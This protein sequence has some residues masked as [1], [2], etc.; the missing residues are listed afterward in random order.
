MLE[1]PKLFLDLKSFW[2]VL[3]LLFFVLALRL[4][5]LYGEYNEFKDKR[6]YYTEVKVLQAYEKWT[7]NNSY[8]ILKLYSPSLN[9]SFFSRTKIRQ[10]DLTSHLWMKLFPHKEML[11]RDY[12]GTSFISSSVR[13]IYEEEDNSQNSLKM[14]VEKQHKKS[15]ISNFYNAIYFATPLSRDLRQKVSL[16]GVSHLMALSGFHLGILSAILF[17]LLR[18]LYRPLQ[19]YY[20]PYR[21]DLYDVG[22]IVLILL[23]FY[24]WFVGSPP[25]LLRSYA[26]MVGAWF[27][28]LLGMELFSFSFLA[29]LVMLLLVIFPKM[30]LSLA[31][32]FSVAGVFYIFLLLHHFSTLNKYLMTLLISF[33]LFVLMLPLVHAVF[34][35]LSSWQLLSPLFSLAFSIFYPI[36]MFFHLVGMGDFLDVPLNA[37]FSLSMESQTFLLSRGYLFAYVALSFASIFSKWIFYLLLFI[38]FLFAIALFSGFLV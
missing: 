22:F 9:L 6:F 31:F 7:D 17:F 35:I 30:L 4:F 11:F 33:S 15:E 1:K 25:S 5:S 8:T 26:M 16:L 23:A 32:W 13:E 28:L 10:Y 38:T 21:F 27:L 2:V 3:F 37:L 29:T 19:Q 18:L 36:S 34:P 12:L 20:F 14:W 24:V